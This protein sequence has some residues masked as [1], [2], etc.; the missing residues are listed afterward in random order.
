MGMQATANMPSVHSGKCASSHDAR[1]RARIRAHA[2]MHCSPSRLWAMYR[3]CAAA[4]CSSAAL[5]CSPNLGPQTLHASRGHQRHVGAKGEVV[6]GQRHDMVRQVPGDDVMFGDVRHARRAA[7]AHDHLQ[8]VLQHAHHADDAL[9]AVGRQGVEHRPANAD[10]RCAE[11]DRLED[12]R[13]AAD[14]AIDEH[15]EVL[16]LGPDRLQGIHHL[17]QHLDARTASVQ[18]TAAVVRQHATCEAGLVGSNGILAALHALQENLH[19]GDALDPRHVIPAEAR[20]DVAADGAGCTLGAVNLALIL[21]VGLHIRALLREFA[22][23]VLLAAAELGRVDGHEERLHTRGLQ[24][25]D[26]LLGAAALGVHVELREEFLARRT[27]GQHLIQGV[28]AQSGQHVRQAGLLGG[29]HDSHLTVLVRELREGRGR[30]VQGQGGGGA[31][32]GRRHVDIPDVHE[33]A[34]AHGDA[35]ESHVVVT[36]SDLVVTSAGVVAPSLRLHDLACNGLE[37]EGVKHGGERRLLELDILLDRRRRSL[38]LLGSG[39]FL[40]CLGD[41]LVLD[42]RRVNVAHRQRR[43]Q[44]LLHDILRVDGV[45]HLRR[46]LARIVEDERGTTRVHL[47][48]LGEVVG[49]AVKDDPAI[50][51]GVVLGHLIHGERRK[52]RHG[53]SRALGSEGERMLRGDTG[54]R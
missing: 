14:A 7:Q 30:E 11:R 35:L 43:L 9:L 50:L 21:S 10:A 36:Q 24:L 25:L 47:A 29:P 46:I 8:L 18:L 34:R 41:V 39:M 51:L 19:V 4:T 1:R 3:C 49:L 23:H 44:E 52:S 27:R 54:C 26:V 42:G 45:E 12:I 13:A 48:E 32:E 17:R 31:E 6:A 16:L 28:G 22:A 5:G 38:L 20:V 53:C 37:V 40:G 33:N 2:I 15:R